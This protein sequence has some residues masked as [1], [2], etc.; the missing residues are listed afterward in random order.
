MA[1]AS[2]DVVTVEI[3]GQRYPIRSGLDAAYVTKLASYVDEK[4][5]A[6]A[7]RTRGG[8]SV[9]VAVVAALNIADEYFRCQDANG[10]AGRNVRR[11][12][13]ELEQLVEAALSE[14]SST[15][16]P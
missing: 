2:T 14:A 7:E 1:D 8:D 3:F 9:R 6:T 11:V 16:S 15:S 13:L 10:D 4:M 5:Q 12:A